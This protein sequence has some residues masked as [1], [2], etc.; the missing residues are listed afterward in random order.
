MIDRCYDKFRIFVLCYH[1][2]SIFPFTSFSVIDQRKNFTVIMLHTFFF[3]CSILSFI[4]VKKVVKVK[5]S[6]EQKKHAE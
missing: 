2:D 5:D 3:L 4:C 1:N 6:E